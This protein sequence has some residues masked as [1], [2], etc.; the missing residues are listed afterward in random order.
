[1]YSHQIG[2]TVSLMGGIAFLTA[3]ALIPGAPAQLQAAGTFVGVTLIALTAGYFGASTVA[4]W[5]RRHRGLGLRRVLIVGTEAE[6]QSYLA[7]LNGSL[8]LVNI[9]G[10]VNSEANA[11]CL[12]GGVHGDHHE[13]L[14]SMIEDLT[15]DEV[16]LTSLTPVFD[17]TRLG[18]ECAIRGIAFS[19][20][21]RMPPCRVGRYTATALR[22]GEYLLSL[23]SVPRQPILL[24]IKR[25]IDIVGSIVGLLITAVAYVVYSRRISRETSGSVFF[26][27]TR[28]GRNGRLFTLYKFRTMYIDAETRLAELVSKNEMKGHMFKMRDDPRV[29][30]KGRT[31]RRR[32]IDEL[33]QF[34]NVLR[35]DMSLVG[36]R[37]PMRAEVLQYEKHHRRRLSMKPGITGLWQILGN[38][39]VSEF[40]EIVRLDCQYIENWSFWGDIKILFR[41]ILLLVRGNG[42]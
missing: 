26:K 20:I 42:W 7:S 10:Y 16:V 18:T 41:T 37:P 5:L 28:V 31:M 13:S 27:Q 23:E 33:P 1:M 34:W 21:V 14:C 19:E 11:A 8:R 30:P 2:T 15:V 12:S 36:T 39:S 25:I 6:A 38:E 4:E 24:A 22:S 29:T 40:E 3:E 35:G 17:R 9:V 32:H